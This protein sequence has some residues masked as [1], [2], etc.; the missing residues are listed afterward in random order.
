[1]DSFDPNTWVRPSLVRSSIKSPLWE[2][3]RK[4]GIYKLVQ[5]TFRTS[6]VATLILLR[7]VVTLTQSGIEQYPVF[8]SHSVERDI[9]NLKKKG[10]TTLRI[11]T[12]SPMCKIKF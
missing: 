7:V 10:W 3:K 8:T 5:G 1:M 6:L 11:F 4:L 9:V 2:G 12:L